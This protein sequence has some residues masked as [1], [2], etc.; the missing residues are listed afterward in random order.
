MI[1]LGFEVIL[2]N[3]DD[4]NL[5]H[6]IFGVVPSMLVISFGCATYGLA[7]RIAKVHNFGIS[8]AAGC[9]DLVDVTTC[10]SHG[11]A[12]FAAQNRF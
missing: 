5:F 8:G 7:I 3:A 2:E 10:F 12:V 6:Y 9:E 11:I 4:D 1:I